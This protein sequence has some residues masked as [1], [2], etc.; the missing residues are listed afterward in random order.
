ML[1]ITDIEKT[2]RQVLPPTR[3]S[4]ALSLTQDEGLSFD[5][6]SFGDGIL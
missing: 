3:F 2:P 4:T 5:Y 6:C 1:P